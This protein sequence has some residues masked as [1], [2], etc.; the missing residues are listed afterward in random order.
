M[1]TDPQL[2]ADEAPLDAATVDLFLSNMGSDMVLVG[3][4]ALAFWMDRFG[5]TAEGAVVSND[6]DALGHAARARDLAR[7]MRARLV[8]PKKASRT[9]IVAQLRLPVGD[10]K[11]RNIDILHQLYTIN[12]LRKSNEFTAKV[13]QDSVLVE[14]RKDR[15]IRV[16]DPFD[17]LES[18][19]QNAVGLLDEKGP[20]VLTQAT[21]AI[22]VA[23]AA[24]MKLAADPASPDRLGNK[25]QR[26]YKLAHS[27]VG[28]RL[29]ADHH[30]DVLD[31]IDVDALSTNSPAHA[32]QLDAVAKA[33][34]KRTKPG[35][36]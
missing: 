21:W 34:A 31:A 36:T 26:L 29:L 18:R 3:G 17:L 6:G 11:E 4:Q 32:P 22:H 25:I 35:A 15:F 2:P 19:T 7:E 9:A 27:Q 24:L 28:K 14:W 13:V 30:I 12:G 1:A 5:I 8:Q 23:K 20:H 33:R 10:G 16:M